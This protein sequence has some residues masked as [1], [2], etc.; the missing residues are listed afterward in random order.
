VARNRTA[1]L[2]VHIAEVV[3]AID[4]TNGFLTHVLPWAKQIIVSDK[5][6]CRFVF[7]LGAFGLGP[8][9]LIE[10]APTRLRDSAL[11][12]G[13]RTRPNEEREGEEDAG[14]KTNNDRP[15]RIAPSALPVARRHELYR[16]FFLGPQK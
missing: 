12:D 11:M 6:I 2:L 3:R 16:R 15:S 9:N 14:G 1:R 8:L 7:T 5:V 4:R 10:I 13:M